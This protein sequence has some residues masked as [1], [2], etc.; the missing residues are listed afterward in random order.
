MIEFHTPWCPW[1]PC[2]DLEA[3]PR[4][5]TSL[6]VVEWPRLRSW[7]FWDINPFRT[8]EWGWRWQMGCWEIPELNGASSWDNHQYCGFFQ[9]SHAWLPEGITTYYNHCSLPPSL[10]FHHPVAMMTVMTV[11]SKDHQHRMAFRSCSWN[12]YTST[13]FC[14]L[15]VHIDYI[16]YNIVY[17]YTYIYIHLYHLRMSILMYCFKKLY[18]YLISIWYLYNTTPHSTPSPQNFH[19][20]G[21]RTWPGALHSHQRVE[22]TGALEI[23]RNP[24]TSKKWQL[25]P[26]IYKN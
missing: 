22:T 17:I 6:Q 16:W 26:R 11:M 9:A 1:Y 18:Q 4:C 5:S 24:L 7:R 21:S 13:W 20:W 23:N 14:M 10:H 25:I 3:N 19:W 8:D 2:Q 12:P 15:I